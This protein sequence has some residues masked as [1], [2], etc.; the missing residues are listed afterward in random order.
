MPALRL[1]LEQKKKVIKVI[2][3]LKF[4]FKEIIPELN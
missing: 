1:Y 4:I 3:I 2:I